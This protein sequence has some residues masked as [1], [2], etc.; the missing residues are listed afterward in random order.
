MTVWIREKVSG[1][2]L[3]LD[4]VEKGYTN[5]VPDTFSLSSGQTGF[6]H[7]PGSPLN[8]KALFCST[9]FSGLL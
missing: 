2:L 9:G 6:T 5:K 8:Q 4:E 3:V 7:P 1:T